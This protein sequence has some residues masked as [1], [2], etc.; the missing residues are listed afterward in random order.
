MS[1]VAGLQQLNRLASRIEKIAA[2]GGLQPLLSALAAEAHDQTLDCFNQQ[3][4]PYGKA[5]KSRQEP[6]GG[7]PI[8]DKTGAGVES[9]TSR[10]TATGIKIR[11]GKDYMG[12]HLTGTSRMVSRK[13]LPVD[14]L[15]PIWEPAFQR[16]A[17]RTFR[18]MFE[19]G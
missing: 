12:F 13:F 6:T 17:D 16:V 4:D 1:P 9:I 18:K 5:W 19:V 11:V 15:G 10:P 8:L 14:G 2:A 7:W 3:R